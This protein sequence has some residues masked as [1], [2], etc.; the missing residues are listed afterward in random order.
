MSSV[1]KVVEDS[2]ISIVVVQLIKIQ[3]RSIL[4]DRALDRALLQ[5]F[6]S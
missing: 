3:S 4:P 5:C 1:K 6:S 2:E